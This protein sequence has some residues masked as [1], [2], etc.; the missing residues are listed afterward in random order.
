MDWYRL[1]CGGSALRKYEEIINYIKGEILNS[2]IKSGNKLYS[3]RDVS[4]RFQCSKATVIKAYE[5]LE[6]EKLIYSIPKSGYYLVENKLKF[7]EERI[8]NKVDFNSAYPDKS[9][10]PY[11]EFQ[12]CMDMAM[13]IYRERLFTNLSA[14]G[15]PS[16][17]NLAVKELQN[18]Q[19]FANKENVF[20]TSGSQ[21]AINILTMM[22]L[23]NKRKNV[24]VEQPTYHGVLKSLE[25]NHIST[26]G[27]KRDRNGI[28]FNELE[29]IFKGYDIKFF[30]VIPRFHNPTGFSY[31]SDEKKKILKLCQKYDVYIV[32]DDYLGDLEVDSKSDPIYAIDTDERVIYL[33][34]Y[35]KVLLPGL[36][37]AL[38]VLPKALTKI[39]NE[40]KKWN[41]LSTSILSQGA[42][43]IYIKSGM[44]KDN[45]RKIRA[46]Y[47]AR[48]NYLRNLVS[49]VNSQNATWYIPTSGFFASFE[50]NDTSK[51][52]YISK[53][54]KMKNII[55][56]DMSKFYLN[57]V[58][59]H[60]IVRISLSDVDYE[61]IKRGILEIVREVK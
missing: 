58:T 25:L 20:I 46:I 38:A 19:V 61:K 49:E 36:R 22:E 7:Q 33:K 14:K 40:Y 31:S 2:N 17:I 13:E 8:N 42:L 55:L 56:P 24:L 47:T 6:K 21:Q 10:L 44:F 50:V 43:E 60:N 15:L 57:S 5:L 11:E 34:T 16:L 39:F 32:E 45:I 52:N 1:S 18:Y 12:K 37:I 27:I 54:L 53:K 30:Y 51:I 29:R 26:I 48:M 4:S 9:I 41:D 28:D 23:K 35:S 59:E 3:I